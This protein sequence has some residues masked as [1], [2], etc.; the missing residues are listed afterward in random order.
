MIEYKYIRYSEG[1]FLKNSVLLFGKNLTAPC[2]STK[3]VEGR[4]HIKFSSDAIDGVA[5][6]RF[7]STF[8]YF[9]EKYHTNF[10]I[11]INFKRAFLQI[12]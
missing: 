4:L 11:Y 9:D 12:S 2:L 5:L 10:P 8:T 3:F 1:K 6:K 7:I